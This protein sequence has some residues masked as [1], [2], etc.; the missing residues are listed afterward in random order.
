MLEQQSLLLLLCWTCCSQ[1]QH[2]G[3]ALTVP[4]VTRTWGLQWLLL[5]WLRL[6]SQPGNL[7]H[8]TGSCIGLLELS[9]VISA[10]LGGRCGCGCGC[11][12]PGDGAV[13]WLGCSVM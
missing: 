8:T 12:R 2:H 4:A 13:T 9:G 6:P 11:S 5:L 10:V 7:V 1:V 3:T